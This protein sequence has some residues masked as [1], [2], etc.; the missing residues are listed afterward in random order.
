MDV[1][2]AIWS[3]RSAR[4]YTTQP[5]AQDILLQLL[6]AARR[7]PSGG[8]AQGHCFGIV[9]EE[10]RKQA[11][12][13]A[14]GGQ[15][16]IASAPVVLACCADIAWDFADQPE[17]DWGRQINR[18][19]FTPAFLDHLS[20]YPV[21]PACSTLF[22]NATPLMPME[23]ILLAAAAHGIVGCP[24]G[25]LDIPKANAILG[26]PE[27]LSCLFLL[28]LGYPDQPPRDKA[29]KPLEVI[30]FTEQWT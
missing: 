23:N 11:L 13:Q 30:T 16:W 20:Q 28:P 22:E 5:I 25:F 12:A 21:R 8:D 18:M 6:E 2:E 1:M 10:T 7:A 3:R 14:A 17:D 26:L 15:M 29:L 19:R 4:S 27:H 9:R 24:I